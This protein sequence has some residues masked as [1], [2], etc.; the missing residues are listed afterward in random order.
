MSGKLVQIA[1][2]GS[3]WGVNT[4]DNIYRRDVGDSSWTQVS[5][6]LTNVSIRD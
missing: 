2:G 4:H 5:G 3:I 1:S 6:K